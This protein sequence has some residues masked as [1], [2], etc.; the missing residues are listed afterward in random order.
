[1]TVSIVTPSLN[2]GVFI[3]RTI[4]SVINQGYPS[5]EYVIQDG[6]SSDGTKSI[7]ER[8]APFLFAFQAVRDSGQANAI[9]L[10][11]RRTTGDI[12]AYLNA[13][14]VLLPG[15]LHYVAHFFAT[16]PSVEVVY[17]HR[18]L[19]DENDQE[20]GRWILPPHDS[21]ILSWL[22]YVPQ[23]TLFWR[24]RIWEK[25]GGC[26]DE[27]FEFA[28]DWDLLLR[29]SEAGAHFFRVPRFLGAFRVHAE[30]K[31]AGQM[32]TVG[33]EEISKLRERWHG[34]PVSEGEAYKRCR[35]YFRKHIIWH[36]SYKLGILRF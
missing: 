14:D 18:V 13:D 25:V 4:Q 19:I 8:Y 26:I 11:F 10:G 33:R 28:M 3:E 32:S 6:D 7:L 2:Q 17:G 27:R 22:D 24:R 15:T 1:L 12:M 34:R 36:I 35:S 29:F 16:H 20:I 30:Q 9:N 21:E 31:T 5:L 23:E